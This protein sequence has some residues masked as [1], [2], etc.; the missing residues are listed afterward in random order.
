MPSADYIFMGLIVLMGL[1]MVITNKPM[2]IGTDKYTEDSLKKYPRPA[3]IVT[4]LMGASGCLFLYTMR[5][6]FDGKISGWITIECLALTI[7]AII[8][9]IVVNKK[10]LVKK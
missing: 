8:A 3:G 6:F 2:F 1:I 10:I 9:N 4:M 5:L 7:I